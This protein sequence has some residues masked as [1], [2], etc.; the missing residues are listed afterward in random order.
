MDGGVHSR[1]ACRS[2]CDSRIIAKWTCHRVNHG[3]TIRHRASRWLAE[4]MPRR[5]GG[6]QRGHRE[7]G[8]R[9]WPVLDHP[10][11]STL[12]IGHASGFCTRKAPARSRGQ[13]PYQKWGQK[14]GEIQEV[15]NLAGAMQQ[16]EPGGAYLAPRSQAPR[17]QDPPGARV[18]GYGHPN[19]ARANRPL[20]VSQ[21]RPA[22]PLGCPIQTASSY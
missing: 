13:L 3:A 7:M 11:A 5:S 14:M 6:L 21:A 1:G 16:T 8:Y 12:K 22:L 4:E 10:R 2:T 17:G 19:A 15:S 9:V 18:S 20:P